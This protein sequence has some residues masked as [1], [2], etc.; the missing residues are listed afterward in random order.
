VAKVIV[1][2]PALADDLAENW[3]AQVLALAPAYSHIL[4]SATPSTRRG[5]AGQPGW[6]SQISEIL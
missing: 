1:D 3:A 4:F 5:A 2:A 6:T